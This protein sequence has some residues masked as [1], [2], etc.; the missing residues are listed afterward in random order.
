M[1]G[2]VFSNLNLMR[3]ITEHLLRSNGSI[4]TLFLSEVSVTEVQS[5]QS[6]KVDV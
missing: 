5:L 2:Q 6:E 1:R 3:V 4:L